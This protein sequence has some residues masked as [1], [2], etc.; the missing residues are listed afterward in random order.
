M[1]I[2]F[3][4]YLNTIVC[5]YLT[6][7]HINYFVSDIRVLVK[8]SQA[9]KSIMVTT[10]ED[11]TFQADL[12]STTPTPPSSFNCLTKILGGP[13]QLYASRKDMESTTVKVPESDSYTTSSPLKFYTSCPNSSGKDEKCGAHNKGIRSS[14]TFDIPLPPEWGLAPSSY[15]FPYFF[16]IIGIP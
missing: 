1:V 9:K 3:I 15:Y 8:C 5:W 13:K 7:L 12:P 2:T 16:P 4:N 11:G 6:Y 14:K 10:K